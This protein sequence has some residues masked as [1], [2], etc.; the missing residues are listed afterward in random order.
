MIP[1]R[2]RRRPEPT[3]IGWREV[4]GLPGFGIER[5]RA[6]VDTGARTSALHATDLEPFERDGTPWIAFSVPSPAQRQPVRCF[7]PIADRRAIKNTSGVPETRYIVQTPLVIGRRHWT[8]EVSLSD[9]T[10]MEFDLILGRAAIR[11]HNFVVNPG[12]SYRAG[13][14]DLPTLHH[15][16]QEGAAPSLEATVPQVPG[17]Y[18]TAEGKSQ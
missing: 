2:R 1:A 8:I 3:E 10:E 7:A 16:P 11:G 17:A 14:P 18:Q 13:L 9:R 12:K 5:M 6:K 4:V 15:A